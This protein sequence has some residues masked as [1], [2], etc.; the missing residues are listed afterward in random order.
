MNSIFLFRINYIRKLVYQGDEM[1]KF[2]QL[3]L[4]IFIFLFICVLFAKFGNSVL[5]IIL[6]I[7]LIIFFFKF[8]IEKYTKHY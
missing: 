1:M 5:N 8:L 7:S 6:L 3:L 4:S 2:I